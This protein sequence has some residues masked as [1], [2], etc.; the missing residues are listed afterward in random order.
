MLFNFISTARKASQQK[1]HVKQFLQVN[2]FSANSAKWSHSNNCRQNP[3]NYL[4]LLEECIDSSILKLVYNGINKDNMPP[5]LKLE[6]K[7]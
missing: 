1:H 2:P 5:N 4:S 7:K 6:L 3:T